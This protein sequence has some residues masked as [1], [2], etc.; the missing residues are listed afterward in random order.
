MCCEWAKYNIQVNG[1]GP[2]YIAT[3]QTEAIRADNHPFNNLV[4]TRTPAGRWG[5]P[6]DLVGAALLLASKAGDYINGQ[7]VY[8]D[9]GIL[10][11]FGYVAGENDVK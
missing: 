5:A 1:I 2:G 8:V 9:G 10:A 7:V 6:E 3:A 11:N 4:M